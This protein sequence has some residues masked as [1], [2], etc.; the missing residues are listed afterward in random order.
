VPRAR[1]SD[2]PTQ[3]ALADVSEADWQKCAPCRGGR[4]EARQSDARG[5]R[6]ERCISRM[7]DYLARV[8]RAKRELSGGHCFA[9]LGGAAFRRLA[10]STRHFFTSSGWFVAVSRA[11]L[12]RR[13]TARVVQRFAEMR[14]CCIRA[15]YQCH[16]LTKAPR[17]ALV[18]VCSQSLLLRCSRD[19]YG[20]IRDW[21]GGVVR[22][23]PSRCC[24]T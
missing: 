21:A 6:Q 9:R 7:R 24:W 5:V 15:G 1:R 4:T 11:R 12:G 3:L 22:S 23:S 10:R 18:P 13:A 8:P 16:L 2:T 14:E 20:R 19:T 17:S